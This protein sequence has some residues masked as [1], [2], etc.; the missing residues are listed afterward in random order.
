MSTTEETFGAGDI[1]SVAASLLEVP[2]VDA[3]QDEDEEDAAVDAADDAYDPDEEAPEDE[4]D[5]EDDGAEDDTAEEDDG[6]E[7]HQQ[8]F[9]VKV[10]GEEVD[11]T[12]D[13]LKRSFAG[14]GYIQKRMREVAD[15]RKEAENVYAALNQERAQL[16]QTLAAYQQQLQAG[17]M[18]EKP[19][20]DLLNSD[21]ISYFD[22][23]A[24]YEEA[25]EKARH[26][27]Q[28]SYALEQQQQQLAERAHMALLQQQAQVLAQAI[29]EFADAKTASK[30]KQ[31]IVQS[32]AKY[33]FSPEELTGI[34]DARQVQVLYDAM[35]YRQMMAS[36]QK[37]TEKV[38]SARPV[39]KPGVARTTAEGKKTQAQKVR[40]RMKQSGDVDDVAA[41]LLA[42]G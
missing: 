14:Q 7:E 8:R 2:A 30:L 11:V 37:V 4:A 5:A 31:D 9:R 15:V 16:A 34:A 38:A 13:D 28:T 32:A 1:D 35:R 36:K 21:P 33:G 12:L 39:I 26:A 18:P 19:S 17:G 24:A 27:Q 23:L 6:V 22:Q 20:R 25:T 41:F 42:K 29:P 3:T 10:D 40:A